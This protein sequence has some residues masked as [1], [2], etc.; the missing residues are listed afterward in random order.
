MNEVNR[1]YDFK[2]QQ[3]A[4]G[5]DIEA[6]EEPVGIS[7]QDESDEDTELNEE[8]SFNRVEDYD[9]PSYLFIVL[10]PPFPICA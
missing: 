10:F 3:E 4:D 2:T 8:E 1:Q 9:F 7:N 5:I 6:E